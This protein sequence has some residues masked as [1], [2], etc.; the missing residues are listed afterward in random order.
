MGTNAKAT[1]TAPQAP[2]P[3]ISDAEAA[4]LIRRILPISA[5]A[6]GDDAAKALAVIVDRL[7]SDDDLTARDN[8]R[9]TFFR[10]IFCNSAAHDDAL[11]VFL[12]SASIT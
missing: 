2:T 10:A 8:N 11:M 7:A 6:K 3:F 1:T 9:E 12:R 4:A 5:D